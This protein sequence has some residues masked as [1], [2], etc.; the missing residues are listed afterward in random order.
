[1]KSWFDQLVAADLR[2]AALTRVCVWAG[3]GTLV[4]RSVYE[5]VCTFCTL[6]TG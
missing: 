3:A 1:M 5:C 6:D 4:L 2:G